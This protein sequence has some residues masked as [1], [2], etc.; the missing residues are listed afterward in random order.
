M[1]GEAFENREPLITDLTILAA[2]S[3]YTSIELLISDARRATKQQSVVQLNKCASVSK[4]YEGFF[5]EA[6]KLLSSGRAWREFGDAVL[7]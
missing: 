5:E 7:R 2:G 6:G 4:C 3:H 1:R